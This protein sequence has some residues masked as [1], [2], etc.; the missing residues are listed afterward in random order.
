MKPS[1]IILEGMIT[2]LLEM[3]KQELELDELPTIALV[4]DRSIMEV[5]DGT[6]FGEFTNNGIKVITANRHPLDVCRT[7][8][9]ELVHWKQMLEGQ[10]MDGSDGS[11]TENQANAIAGI[12]L[13]KFGK[14]YPECFVI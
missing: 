5:G 6:S 12:I 4:N 10:Q 3:C 7:L 9:H 2:R 14:A 11:N 13:R 8:C 1:E